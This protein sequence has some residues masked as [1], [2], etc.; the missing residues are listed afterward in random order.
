MS[1]NS[2]AAKVYYEVAMDRLQRQED[3]RHILDTKIQSAF[4]GATVLISV[5]AATFSGNTASLTTWTWLFLALALAAYTNVGIFSFLGYKS[6]NWS[7]RPNLEDLATRCSEYEENDMLTWVADECAT[8]YSANEEPV[9][10]KA[11]Y[12][13]IALVLIAVEAAFLTAARLSAV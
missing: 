7:F 4:A 1:E 6:K 10:M 3:R 5:L 8:S 2:S 13:N 9:R 11:S 12:L